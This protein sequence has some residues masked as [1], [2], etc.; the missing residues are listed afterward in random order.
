MII[1]VVW[2]FLCI[3]FKIVG[4]VLVEFV[5]KEVFCFLLEGG[6]DEKDVEGCGEG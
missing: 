3:F 6:G 4:D 5:G 2:V 1:V